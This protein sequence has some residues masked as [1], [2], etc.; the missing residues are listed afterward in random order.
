[1]ALGATHKVDAAV[2]A[3][4]TA[5]SAEVSAVTG[6]AQVQNVQYYRHRY[7]RHRFYHRRY[8]RY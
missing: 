5:P 2:T 8:G 1:M 4:L 7:Y 3:G 6:D